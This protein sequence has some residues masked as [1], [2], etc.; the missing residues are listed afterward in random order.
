MTTY[1]FLGNEIDVTRLNNDANGNPMY[2]VH[3][4]VLAQYI[5]SALGKGDIFSAYERTL[6]YARRLGMKKHHV[7]SYG[8]GL[9]FSSFNVQSDLNDIGARLVAM[10]DDEKTY[11]VTEEDTRDFMERRTFVHPATTST[12]SYGA[13]IRVKFKCRDISIDTRISFDHNKGVTENH[14]TA[15]I[16]AAR[17]ATKQDAQWS[18]SV[19]PYY[20]ETADGYTFLIKADYVGV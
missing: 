19:K 3:Y 6:S 20:S 18:Y 1:N 10:L 9:K 16:I 13:Q 5:E 14:L 17:L 2:C 15:A 7:R 11:I 12:V 4:L 8:G